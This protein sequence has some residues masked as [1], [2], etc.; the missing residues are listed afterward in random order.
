M[1][2]SLTSELR[3]AGTAL[4][5]GFGSFIRDLSENDE[6]MITGGGRDDHD[7]HDD[8]KKGDRHRRKKD[9]KRGNKDRKNKKRC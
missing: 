9:R 3:P 2:N 7:D 8:R 4:F 5:S 6:S 1:D